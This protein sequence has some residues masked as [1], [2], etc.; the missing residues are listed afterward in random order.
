MYSLL[1]PAQQQV[2]SWIED[3]IAQHRIA[4][5]HRDIQKG[6]QYRSPASIQSHIEALANKGFISHI[7]RKPRSIKILK[8]SRE[9]PVLGSIAAHSLV[10]VFPDTEIEYLDL[11]FLPKFA[12]LSQYELTQHFALRVRGDSM[13]GALIADGDIVVLR[14]ESDPRAI[15]NGA[16]VAAR[17]NGATTLKHYYRNGRQITLQPANP[18]YEPTVLNANSAEIE[19][20]G[21]YI[22]VALRGGF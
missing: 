10:E 2:F 9:I 3:Y 21:V 5:T 17:V 18:H 15:R 16:I 12:R 7:P 19:V 14:R 8:S 22:N 11:S 13:V 4:P 1:T 20:Q 6:L